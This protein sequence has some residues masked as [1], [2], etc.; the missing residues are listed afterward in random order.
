[1][2]LEKGKE[3]PEAL[4]KRFCSEK[5]RDAYS[6]KEAKKMPKKGGGCCS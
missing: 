1:M 2:E 6:E 5:C 3:Y 4:G